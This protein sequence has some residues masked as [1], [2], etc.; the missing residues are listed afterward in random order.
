MALVH[1][2]AAAVAVAVALAPIAFL[3]VDEQS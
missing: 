1:T 2:A 3:A